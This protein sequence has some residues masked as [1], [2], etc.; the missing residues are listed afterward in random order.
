MEHVLAYISFPGFLAYPAWVEP[1]NSLVRG[2]VLAP[3]LTLLILVGP[4]RIYVGAHWAS[5]VIGAYLLGIVW[6]SASPRLY[7]AWLA[8]GA[9]EAPSRVGS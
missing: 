9:P 1:R 7:D 6:L 8:R 4:A 2:L 5:D 3:C